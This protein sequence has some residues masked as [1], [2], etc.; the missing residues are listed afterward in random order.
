MKFS[1]QK[2][3]LLNAVLTTSKAAA[4]KSTISA[5]EGV[6]M[7][8]DG[9]VLTITGYDLDIGIRTE[10]PVNGEEDGSIIVNAKIA[11]E[12]IRKMPSGDITFSCDESNVAIIKNR[13]AEVSIMCISADDYP[14]V[15][16]VNPETSFTMPQK[17]L[18]S[19][20]NQTKYACS[21]NDSKPA[22]MG[23]KFEIDNNLLNVVAVDGIRIALRQEPVVYDNIDFI[24]PL[25]SLEELTHILSDES[26]KDV[27]LCIDKNQISFEVE[28]YTMISRLIDG[29]F[30][31]YKNHL[32][33]DRPI[34]AEVNCREIME[35]LDRCMLI[36]NEKNKCPVRCEFA[37]NSLSMSC[38]TALGKVSDRITIK[39]DGTP[40]VIGFNAKYLMDAI[41]AADTDMV[42]MKMTPSSVSPIIIVPMEGKEFTFLLLPMR[43]K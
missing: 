42:K 5:L 27:T 29:E 33:G 28:N 8:L 7:K 15:P 23:C 18:K 17:T 32:N 39:Y 1:C 2:E 11:G 13:D 37:D 22:L 16:S 20:I 30:I 26:D 35:M 10:L 43:L 25:K 9:N 36:I 6:L 40:T 34:C 14:T 38:T 3:K 4:S 21:L 31:P 12:I 41:K 24:V 19:M